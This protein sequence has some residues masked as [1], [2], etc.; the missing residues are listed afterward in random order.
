MFYFKTES[1]YWLNKHVYHNHPLLI[2]VIIVSGTND[3][4]DYLILLIGTLLCDMLLSID[5]LP[6]L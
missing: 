5:F 6:N 2:K 3:Y 1:F 4:Y